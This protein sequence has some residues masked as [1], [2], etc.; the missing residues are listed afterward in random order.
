MYQIRAKR[1]ADD[2][3]V[4]KHSVLKLLMTLCRAWFD[5]F[6]AM[7]KIIKKRKKNR[8]RISTREFK[9]MLRRFESDL[10]KIKGLWRVP[11]VNG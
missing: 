5:A 4:R 11:T 7:P 6:I 3:I 10:Y 8:Y 9:K 1:K 2:S